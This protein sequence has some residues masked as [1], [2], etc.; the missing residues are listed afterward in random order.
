MQISDVGVGANGLFAAIVT[1]VTPPVLL[2]LAIVF[3]F[4]AYS[5]KLLTLAS[6][7]AHLE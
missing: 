5:A 7:V 6:A 4:P 1:V 3:P 2:M